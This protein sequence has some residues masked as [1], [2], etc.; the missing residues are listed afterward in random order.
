M[1]VVLWLWI[2]LFVAP[3]WAAGEMSRG[4]DVYLPVYSHMA[5]GNR[6]RNGMLPK[7]MLSAMVSVRNTDPRR[8]MRLVFAKYYD[9]EGKFLKDFVTSPMVVPPFGTREF[10]VD[11]HDDRGGSGANFY[12]RWEA[13]VAMNPPLIEAVHANM[14]SGKSVIVTTRGVVISPD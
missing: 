14:D 13:D 6:N 1:R 7:A 8:G 2:G 12:L 9:T 11:L 5:Y 3:A 4:Q 10:F